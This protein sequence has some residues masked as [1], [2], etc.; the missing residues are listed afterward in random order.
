VVVRGSVRVV[1]TVTSQ[2]HLFSAEELQPRDYLQWR[3]LRA[4]LAQ[5]EEC[6]RLQFCFR[7][8]PVRYLAAREAQLLT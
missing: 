1:A 5:R 6:R 7:K 3:Q 8:D 4:Q 2:Q